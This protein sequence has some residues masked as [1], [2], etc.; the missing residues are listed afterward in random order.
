MPATVSNCS[1]VLIRARALTGFRALVREHDG[2]C[3]ALLAAAGIPGRA[4]DAPDSLL[5]LASV[6]ALLTTSASTLALPDFGL[7][8]AQKQ[9]I[10]V[11]GPVALIARHSATLGEALKAV[12]RNMPYHCPGL[13]MTVE[14]D[15]G[16][17]GVS[18]CRFEFSAGTPH[19]RRHVVELCLGVA[20]Q[21]FLAVTGEDGHDWHIGFRHASPLPM[22]DYGKYFRSRVRLEQPR[23]GLAFPSAL[24]DI[25]I[26]PG[27]GSLQAAA[28]RHVVNI[29]RRFPLDLPQ[30]VESV[31]SRHL[32]D[33]GSSLVQIAL[34][35]GIHERTLQR[36]LKEH[37][38]VFEEI[39]DCVRRSRAEQYLAQSG[40][41]LA[42]L[43]AMLG[44]TE[45]SS[46][47]RGC[48][49]WFG[50][51]PQAY[52]ALRFGAMA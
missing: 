11:L 13:H 42:E 40:M 12:A 14:H 35:M 26:A 22:A 46:F 17:P 52:R 34:Q 8:L 37:D 43:A 32:A 48:R 47:I 2:D 23:N 41:P 20:E 10:G 6:M 21:F 33:G 45:Q 39:V 30:Q 29:M 15:A 38:M 36:R 49:R 7:R 25:A 4:L 28:E 31:V 50:Q 18:L 5:C 16:R 44:Y 27:E 1:K 19:T 51:T 24:L 3:A 9:D